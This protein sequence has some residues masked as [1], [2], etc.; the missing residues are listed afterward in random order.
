MIKWIVMAVCLAATPAM[1]DSFFKY[2]DSSGTLCFTDDIDR[3]PEKYFDQAVEIT[4]EELQ[5]KVEKK[6]TVEGK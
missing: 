5:E 1:A 6:W 3:I 2:T 4:T